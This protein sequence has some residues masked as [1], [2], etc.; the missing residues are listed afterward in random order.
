MTQVIKGKDIICLIQNTIQEKKY[1]I[2]G[3]SI[4]FHES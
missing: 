3:V 4:T 2:L 1:W